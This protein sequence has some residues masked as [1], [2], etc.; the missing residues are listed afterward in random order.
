MASV[1]GVDVGGTFTDLAWWDGARLVVGKT[2]STE[3]QSDGVETGARN[4]LEGS[5]TAMLV[6][7]TTVAT[8]ALLERAGVETALVTD[9]GFEDVIEIGRQHRPSLYDVDRQRAAPLTPRSLRFGWSDDTIEELRRARPRAVAVSLLNAYRDGA[10]E[11]EIVDRLDELDVPVVASHR[12]SPE[13]REFERTSTTL[14]N[15]YLQPKVADYLRKLQGRVTPAPADRLMVMRSSGGLISPEQAA[16]LSASIL[17][18]G[19]AGGVVAAAALGRALGLRRV[20]SFDMGGTSTDVCRI[21]DGTPEVGYEREI[22]GIVVRMPS[23]AVHTV[24]AGGGSIG[25][26]DPGGALRVGPRSAGASPG[27]VSYARGGTEPA[28]TD[29][30]VHLGRLA[31][32]LAGGVALDAAAASRA[33]ERLGGSAGT[34]TDD[35]ALGMLEVVEATME[36]AVRVVSVEEGADPSEAAL[37]AFGGA[38]GLHAAALARRLEMAS[39]IVPPHAGV[40]SALGMLLAPARF[41]HAATVLT[42]DVDVVT[43]TVRRLAQEASSAFADSVGARPTSLRNSVD[44]RYVGQAHETSVPCEDGDD[45]DSLCGRFH[46]IHR[47]RNGFDRVDDPVEAVTV[48]VV[49]TGDPAITWADLP[50]HRPGGPARIEDRAVLTPRGVVDVPVWVRRGLGPGGEITGPCIVVDGEATTWLDDGDTGVVLD[51][52]ALEVRW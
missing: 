7:G 46:A 10:A 48:R 50:E 35:T 38:G 5:R 20:I 1:L 43:S 24:G 41:D 37:V 17:L 52:G 31:G 34:S 14:V 13:F 6:H 44:M 47:R 36:R 40:F 39:M 45:W 32:S 33:L 21:E 29:A 22:D 28:V 11:S 26:T 9:P 4:V 27:P 12:V 30:H 18:S 15:A 16:D 42:T 8:N 23:V 2:P 19:P 51:S 25:W 3:D 49:A